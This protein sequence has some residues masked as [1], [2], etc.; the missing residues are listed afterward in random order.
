MIR[1]SAAALLLCA[2]L[3]GCA[4]GGRSRGTAGERAADAALTQLGKPYRF[5]SADPDKGFDC[6]GLVHYS[7]AA[8]G[9]N[10]PRS[11]ELLYRSSRKVSRGDLRRGD[12]VFFNVEGKN[13]SHVGIYLGK[14]EFVHAP[15]SGGRVRRESLDDAYWRKHL[16]GLRRP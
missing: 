9:V 1:A 4:G 13:T 5:G 15:S 12:L 7:Y 11:T 10:V 8:A 14:G 3:T 16:A 2:L 6:S